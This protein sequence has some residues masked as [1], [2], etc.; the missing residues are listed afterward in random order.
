MPLRLQAGNRVSDRDAQI[1]ANNAFNPDPTK[2]VRWGPQNW[3]EMSNCFIGLIFD[4]HDDAAQL[5]RRSGPSLLA[6]GHS[7]PTLAALETR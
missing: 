5:F 4:V 2:E 7:G 1:S 6:P 3:D